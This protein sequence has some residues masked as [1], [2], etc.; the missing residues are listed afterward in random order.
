ME[1]QKLEK[2]R[3]EE[4]LSETE[5]RRLQQLQ[6][7]AVERRQRDQGLSEAELRRVRQLELGSSVHQAGRYSCM[8]AFTSMYYAYNID[9]V[10]LRA[11]L[12]V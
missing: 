10:R 11:E 4:Q 1:R 9:T 7:Q 8:H 6:R 3:Q 12:V 2:K 5:A